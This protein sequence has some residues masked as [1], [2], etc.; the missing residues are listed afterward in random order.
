MIPSSQGRPAWWTDE[1]GAAP[2]YNAWVFETDELLN[3]PCMQLLATGCGGVLYP[4]GLFPPEMFDTAAIREV[5]LMAD[6]LWLKAM[7]LVG[8]VPVVVAT[9]YQGLTYVPGS[10]QEALWRQNL[11]GENDR[12]LERVRRWVDEHYGEGFYA[13]RLAGSV[14]GFAVTG[15]EAVCA[16]ERRHAQRLM[17]RNNALRAQASEL[18]KARD[19]QRKENKGLRASLTFRL[20]RAVTWLPRK[21][22]HL[23]GKK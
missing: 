3:Q 14:D 23:F 1:N 16:Y 20:G 10:Q 11:S 8:G 6:D 13:A 5:C 7:E 12:A 4:P 17:R 22:L 18:A 21:L 2:E 19:R 9:P 15:F